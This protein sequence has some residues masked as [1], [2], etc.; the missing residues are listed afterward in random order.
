MCGCG[1]ALFLGVCAGCV[2]S[3]E[4]VSVWQNEARKDLVRLAKRD[5]ACAAMERQTPA[6]GRTAR[7]CLGL[8]IDRQ[9][10]VPTGCAHELRRIDVRSN[11]PSSARGMLS[12]DIAVSILCQHPLA[13]YKCL[14]LQKDHCCY[15]YYDYYGD[16][17]KERARQYTSVKC[18]HLVRARHMS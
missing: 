17:R 16:S 2:C 8:L 4:D 15:Y 11:L 9:K 12:R 10:R 13:K 7:G 1:L 18:N 14:H 5:N 3:H 6:K